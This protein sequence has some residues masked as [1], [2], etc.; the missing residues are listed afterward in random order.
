MKNL[1]RLSFIMFL[2][3]FVISCSDGDGDG[4]SSVPTDTA[5]SFLVEYAGVI[6][7]DTDNES[8]ESSWFSVS[9]TGFTSWGLYEGNCDVSVGEWD[10]VD[11]Y[12]DV[13][14][15]QT[16]TS[17]TLVI[18]VSCAED[19]EGLDDY[20]V[21]LTVTGD[22]N[23]LSAVDSDFPDEVDYWVRDDDGGC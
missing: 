12:G 8:M 18:L 3:L 10:E 14:S 19:C 20:T 13:S 5:G 2:S 1:L 11:E 16:N 6:W 9:P 22:G 7:A 21:T 15:V 4:N 23:T 17:N